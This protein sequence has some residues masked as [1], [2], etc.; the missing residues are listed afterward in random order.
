MNACG[1]A[2]FHRSSP[3]CGNEGRAGRAYDDFDSIAV[4]IGATDAKCG[5]GWS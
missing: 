2:G 4:E 5:M 3:N 1:I